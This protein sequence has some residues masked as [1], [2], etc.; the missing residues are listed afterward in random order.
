[1]IV[2]T[3]Q[4]MAGM[5]MGRLR[6]WP[7]GSVMAPNGNIGCARS[8]KK[9][10]TVSLIRQKPA[11]VPTRSDFLTWIFSSKAKESTIAASTTT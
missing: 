3:D 6:V 5:K 11:K 1:M 8:V 7:L 2:I 4:S 9:P 10:I